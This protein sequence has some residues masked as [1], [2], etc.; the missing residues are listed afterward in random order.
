MGVDKFDVIIIG[1]GLAGSSAA[2]ALARGGK[3]VLLIERG[4]FAGAKN[5]SGG[6]L[7]AYSLELLEGGMTMKAPLERRVVNEQIMLLTEGRS[8]QVAF[9]NPAGENQKAGSYTVL[10]AVLDEWLA[11]QA[12]AQG[13][14]LV[15]NIR[16]DELLER[17]GEIHG[18]VAGGDE[19]E[20]DL[21]IAA[22]GVNSFMAQKA[23]LRPDLEPKMVGV[24]VKEIIELPEEVI[25]NRFGLRKGEGAARMILGGTEGINGGGFLYTNRQSLSL[26]C[27]LTAEALSKSKRSIHAVFQDLKMHPALAPLLEGGTSLEYGAHLVPEAGWKGVPVR[28]HR[29]GFLTVGDAAGFVIN[30]GY[31]I[32]GMDLAIVSGLAAAQAVLANPDRETVGTAYLRQLNEMGLLATMQQYAEFPALM[33]N[34]RLFTQYPQILNDAGRLLFDIDG[35]SPRLL[36]K[37]LMQLVR[38]SG[39][40]IA[41]LRDGWQILRA[42]K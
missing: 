5:V 6:R 2:Y 35:M 41:L 24:G 10:R 39:G 11:A 42:L 32:R 31:T 18:V 14:M 13:G 3:S 4:D 8:A 19:M 34:Q 27:V 12:E 40:F 21:V 9:T 33:E 30:Q 28:L 37:G 15:A 16:V 36:K 26:G 7:Y 22:D 1:A 25:E 29:P 38:E 23:G 17:D 20:A